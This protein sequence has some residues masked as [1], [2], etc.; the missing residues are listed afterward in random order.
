MSTVETDFLGTSIGATETSIRVS[1]LNGTFTLPEQGIS[2]GFHEGANHELLQRS[3]QGIFRI[4]GINVSLPEQ[5]FECEVRDNAGYIQ[6]AQ[7]NHWPVVRF[8]FDFSAGP[9]TGEIELRPVDRTVEAIVLVT[10]LRY[11]LNAAG[12][13]RLVEKPSNR[14]LLDMTVGRLTDQE[15][16]DVLLYAKLSR[17]LW[18]LEE[19]F[20]ARFDCPDQFTTTDLGQLETLFRGVTEG[21]FST[22][23]SEK[24]FNFTPSVDQLGSPPFSGPGPIICRFSDLYFGLLGQRLKTGPIAIQID[25]AMLAN[26]RD[27][28]HLRSDQPMP[29]GLRFVVLDSQ[30]KYR[31]ENYTS[32]PPQEGQKALGRFR[33]RLL[34]QEPEELAD[35][36]TEPLI[37]DVSAERARQIVTGWLQFYDFPDRYCP[38]DPILEN[39][40]WRVPVWITYPDGRGALVQDVFVDLKSGVVSA[41]VSPEEMRNLGKSA[42]AKLLRA[43]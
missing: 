34:Q 15:H 8:N 24:F 33:S 3:F 22:R 19:F 37:S 13:C 7:M 25:R 17:K 14:V 36:L 11:A 38:Q 10:R 5:I 43:S 26:P 29:E 28:H 9:T 39:D 6:N 41:S 35:L 21:E 12:T 31:F 4:D 16:R 40:S 18:F 30:V 23:S 27:L 32:T 20:G 42:A 1:L 2:A